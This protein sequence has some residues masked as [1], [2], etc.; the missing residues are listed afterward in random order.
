MATV[1]LPVAVVCVTSRSSSAAPCGGQQETLV[2]CDQLGHDSFR[3]KVRSEVTCVSRTAALA[4]AYVPMMSS[5]RRLNSP[6]GSDASGSDAVGAGSS[7]EVTA[8]WAGTGTSAAV[9]D[10][11]LDRSAE[12]SD[13]L[14]VCLFFVHDDHHHDLI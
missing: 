2:T 9:S 14:F 3:V 1:L 12:H 6:R 10:S 5:R 11:I 8:G 13:S 7:G 4:A